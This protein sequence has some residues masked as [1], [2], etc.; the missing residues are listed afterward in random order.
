MNSLSSRLAVAQARTIRSSV[1]RLERSGC[2]PRSP[3]CRPRRRS[4]ASSPCLSPRLPASRVRASSAPQPEA[5]LELPARLLRARPVVVDARLAAVLGHER[6]D[7]VGVVGAA[8]GAAV[9][10]RDPPALRAGGLAGEAH[11]LDELLADLRPPLVRELG[12]L[13]VQRQG[14][15]P[16]VRV[17]RAGHPA[18]RLVALGDRH[19]ACR[20]ARAAHRG[21]APARSRRSARAA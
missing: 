17:P 19:L 15:V 3:S 13:R 14:A 12:L 1:C 5:L 20:T 6:D 9:A 16:H 18:G 8:G 10:D 2:S 7:Q 4:A 21:T 11:L